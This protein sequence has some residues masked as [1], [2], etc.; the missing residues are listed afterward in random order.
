MGAIGA[1][2]GAAVE[3]T[4]PL[5]LQRL[6]Q[7]LLLE[8]SC[9]RRHFHHANSLS[10]WTVQR[11]KQHRV[12]P[13]AEKS[14][15]SGFGSRRN[16]CWARRSHYSLRTVRRAMRRLGASPGVVAAAAAAA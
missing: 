11:R 15:E 7:P 1:V 6:E 16:W 5:K 10:S 13:P 3:A 12:D 9:T 14:L 8:P 4:N 2:V